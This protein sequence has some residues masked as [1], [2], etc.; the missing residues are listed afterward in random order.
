MTAHADLGP[1]DALRLFFEDVAALPVIDGKRGYL[2]LTRRIRRAE[3]LAALG[4][5]AAEPTLAALDKALR[6]LWRDVARGVVRRPGPALLEQLDGEIEPFL[7]AP[8]QD[9][10][11]A[12]QALA[13]KVDQD[14]E[15]S[16]RLWQDFYWLALRPPGFRAAAGDAPLAAAEAHFA[17]VRAEGQAARNQLLEGTLRYVVNIAADYANRGLPYLDLV[18]EGFFGLLRA[19]SGFDERKGHFQQYAASWIRQR[20]DRAINERAS[21]IRVPVHV[22]EQVARA[23]R[24]GW[25]GERPPEATDEPEAEALEPA[26]PP[27]MPPAAVDPPAPPEPRRG[28]PKKVLAAAEPK[29]GPY[30]RKN[31]ISTSLDD[32]TRVAAATATKSASPPKKTPNRKPQNAASSNPEQKATAKTT[33]AKVVSARQKSP[34]SQPTKRAARKGAA[35]KQPDKQAEWRHRLAIATAAHY[36]LERTRLPLA[37]EDGQTLTFADVLAAPDDVEGGVEARNFSHFLRDYLESDKSAL[38]AK[39]RDILYRRFGLDSEEMTLEEI[40][41]AEGVTRE[42]IRQIEAKAKNKLV[43]RLRRGKMKQRLLPP[44]RKTIL[45]PPPS[46]AVLDG[47]R[48]ADQI[49]LPADDLARVQALIRVYVRRG[50]RSR[51][52][53]GRVGRQELLR[54]VLRELG[55][56]VHYSAIHERAMALVP[57]GKQFSKRETYNRLFYDSNLFRFH[58]HAVFGLVE[59]GDET[60]DD[61]ERVFRHCPAPLLPPGAPPSAF[62]DSLEL[63]RR[64]L[65]ERPRTAAEF[66]RAMRVWAGGAPDARPQEAFNAWYASGL[67]GSLHYETE[68]ERRLTLTAPADA[69]LGQLRAHALAAAARR[70]ERMAELLLGLDALGRPTADAL[71][72]LLYGRAADAFEVLARLRLL[73]GLGG[74]RALGGEWQLTAAGRAALDDLPATDLPDEPPPPDE[75]VELVDL[76][77]FALELDD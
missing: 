56:P 76:D 66:W 58:R 20:M 17:L 21:L 19:S 27:P 44:Q 13:R 74:A 61:G 4:D 54:E 70:V 59:W 5:G 39:Q 1:A 47:L 51:W 15:A 9:A 60:A 41:R 65:A 55:R 22:W 40:G 23:E 34:G 75:L 73:E 57:E 10:P 14:E 50:R 67:V 36:S 37:D 62:F 2:P 32:P 43:Y 48:N 6:P 24:E 26:A 25:V 49:A 69:A 29:L 71:T 77:E 12:L 18:Q 28:R 46:S 45:P 64:L 68:A 52:V 33:V 63:G 8:E 53:V 72:Q 31:L 3:A 7:D 35:Q 16:D 11:P 30:A 38:S 42:R